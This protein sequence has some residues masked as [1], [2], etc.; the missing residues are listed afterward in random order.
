M[1]IRAY[2][3]VSLCWSADTTEA[4]R[5]VDRDMFMRFKGGGVGHKKYGAL[6][7]E[8]ISYASTDILESAQDAMI[9]TEMEAEAAAAESSRNRKGKQNATEVP[10]LLEDAHGPED[11]QIEEDSDSSDDLASDKGDSEDD[12]ESESVFDFS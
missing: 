8:S 5:F 4:Y 3:S 11:I 2:L 6:I 12:S 7:K 10:G 1:S 9:L